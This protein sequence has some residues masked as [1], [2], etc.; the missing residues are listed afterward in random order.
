MKKGLYFS[1]TRGFFSLIVILIFLSVG[2]GFLS[3]CESG[4]V[5]P[6]PSSASALTPTVAALNA[7][8]KAAPTA[9]VTLNGKTIAAPYY[10]ISDATLYSW[11]KNK[12]K[13][14]VVVNVQTPVFY[15]AGHIP[16]AI[17]IPVYNI[18]SKQSYSRLKKY[19]KDV[20][21]TVCWTGHMQGIPID[22]LRAAGFNAVEVGYGMSSWQRYYKMQDAMASLVGGKL[23][24]PYVPGS[25]AYAVHFNDITTTPTPLPSPGSAPNMKQSLDFNAIAHPAPKEPMGY[26][27]LSIVPA[28]MVY[29]WV[30]KALPAPP[31]GYVIIDLREPSAYAAGHIPG[32][33]NIPLE[34]ILSSKSL[35]VLNSYPKGA[36]MVLVGNTNRIQNLPLMALKTLGYN[37]VDMNFGMSSWVPNYKWTEPDGTPAIT[38]NEALHAAN[39]VKP[40]YPITLPTSAPVSAK[41][42]CTDKMSS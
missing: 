3:G 40:C 11:I 8:L 13:G 15:K 27:G 31:K 23:K 19:K 32:A 20:I 2:A 41:T 14:F 37:A 10:Q 26:P 4:K 34:N 22:Y 12:E 24:A 9:T 38:I 7:A 28:K 25:T 1:K 5:A 30:T 6:P 29:G 33:I 42:V 36:E 16:G 35:A 39:T 18:F 17:N 21:V